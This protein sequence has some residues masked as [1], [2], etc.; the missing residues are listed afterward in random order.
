MSHT[1]LCLA[2]SCVSCWGRHVRRAR[3][4]QAEEERHVVGGADVAAGVQRQDAA[5]GHEVVHHRE[6]ALLHFAR[7]L[8]AQDDHLAR[9]AR[10]RARKVSTRAAAT[11]SGHPG[12]CAMCRGCTP[13][14]STSQQPCK[15]AHTCGAAGEHAHTG[16]CRLSTSQALRYCRAG[17]GLV[18]S[19]SA[20]YPTLI[21]PN[22][23]PTAGRAWGRT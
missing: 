4:G 1:A 12:P 23:V 6:D 8:R 15:H 13:V 19:T 17:T 10:A 14:H 11:A 20:G 2:G 3:A 16:S 7:V 18:A 5:L 22:L 9:P 21:Y